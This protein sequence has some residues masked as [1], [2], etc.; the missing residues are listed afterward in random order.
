VAE[1]ERQRAASK[2][3]NGLVSPRQALAGEG[4]GEA[5]AGPAS[6]TDVGASGGGGLSRTATIRRVRLPPLVS[7]GSMHVGAIFTDVPVRAGGA[8]AGAGGLGGGAGGM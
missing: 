5:A 2:A 4:G 3:G 7:M 8:S 6:A 1:R